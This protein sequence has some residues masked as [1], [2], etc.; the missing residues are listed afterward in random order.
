[1]ISAADGLTG[2]LQSLL[3]QVWTLRPL[4]EN[5]EKFHECK[6][7]VVAG[8]KA[9]IAEADTLQRGL[10]ITIQ[11]R[12]VLRPP[13]P[14]TEAATVLTDPTDSMSLTVSNTALLPEPPVE[15]LAPPIVETPAGNAD[16]VEL[17]QL[18]RSVTATMAGALT[19]IEKLAL[20]ARAS[21][22]A[23]TLALAVQIMPPAAPSGAASSG[24]S[25][26]NGE[27]VADDLAQAAARAPTAPTQPQGL[28]DL[29]EEQH[30]SPGDLR[31]DAGRSHRY[32]ALACR[33]HATC[34]QPTFR[35]RK[36]WQ[37]LCVVGDRR[38][39][40]ADATA[41]PSHGHRRKAQSAGV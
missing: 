27:Q 35:W 36:K 31:T 12:A 34:D 7:E 17:Q 26:T 41:T 32:S 8:L 4:W 37:R 1:M 22:Q 21:V 9:L 6:S 18:I 15:T 25:K 29:P 11:A 10:P 13:E 2:R 33:A 38:I 30:T 14:A 23:H 3:D 40:Q 28:P 16:L 20:V 24:P 5:P 39:H 19:D